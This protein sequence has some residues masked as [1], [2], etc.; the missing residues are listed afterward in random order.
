MASGLHEHVK[1]SSWGL[2]F[3]AGVFGL[4]L[5]AEFWLLAN[6][7]FAAREAKRLFPIIGGGA[8]LGGLVGGA[9]PGW[10]A[11]PLGAGN[12]LYIVAA[13]LVVTAVLSL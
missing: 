6:D 1:W 10:L 11:K 13:E 3:W 8:I 9:V 7:L 12:L 4:V 5:V 2:Y